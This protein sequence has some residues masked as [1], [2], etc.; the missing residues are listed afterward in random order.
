MR[1][2]CV[3]IQTMSSLSHSQVGGLLR[4]I[5]DKVASLVAVGAAW[6]MASQRMDGWGWFLFVAAWLGASIHVDIAGSHHQGEEE[7]NSPEG[8]R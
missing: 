1:I 6:W 5:F 4:R 2:P 3:K 8:K 7:N